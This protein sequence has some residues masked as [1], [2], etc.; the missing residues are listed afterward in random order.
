MGAEAVRKRQ[1]IVRLAPVLGKTGATMTMKVTETE[2]LLI[3]EVERVLEE[4]RN[5]GK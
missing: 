3:E 5:S 4:I 1:S 2:A